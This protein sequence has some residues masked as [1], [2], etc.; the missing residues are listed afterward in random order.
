MA[1]ATGADGKERGGHQLP[2]LVACTQVEGGQGMEW[3]GSCGRL[4]VQH[5]N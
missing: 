5:G 2:G 1:G 3:E 4:S